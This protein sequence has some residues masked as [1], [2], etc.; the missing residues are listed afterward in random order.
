[1]TDKILMK[2]IKE[3]LDTQQKNKNIVSHAKIKQ[4]YNLYESKKMKENREKEYELQKQHEK[5]IKQLKEL[6]KEMKNTCSKLEMI[7]QECIEKLNK[8]KL[9]NLKLVGENKS[10]NYKNRGKKYINK[11]MNDINIDVN[12]INNEDYYNHRNKSLLVNRN[13]ML[14]PISKSQKNLLND[15][16]PKIKKNRNNL[17]SI[18]Y[19]PKTNKAKSSKKFIFNNNSSIVS[20]KEK[21]NNKKARKKTNESNKST[22]KQF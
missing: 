8:T 1:M 12:G 5:N 14:T 18:N 20:N 11:S 10:F 16:K 15:K 9:M 19:Y 21:D 3:Q 13:K 6:E 2:M 17:I 22:N 4:E 7:E